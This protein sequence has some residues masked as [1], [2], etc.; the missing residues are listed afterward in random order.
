[1]DRA[2]NH[3]ASGVRRNSEG[4]HRDG[5]PLNLTIEVTDADPAAGHHGSAHH[6]VAFLSRITLASA[7]PAAPSKEQPHRETA[8]GPVTEGFAH[9]GHHHEDAL[10]DGG[11]PGGEHAHEH[12]A[13]GHE[14]D[15]E[16]SGDQKLETAAA[17]KVAAVI[18]RYHTVRHHRPAP[19]ISAAL[20]AECSDTVRTT[21]APD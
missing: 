20:A 14:P 4:V 18:H 17:E 2:S 11:Q 21:P 1:M 10:G 19:C 5:S 8:A 6:D 3:S 15:H 12:G 16:E 7:G 9:G 13:D